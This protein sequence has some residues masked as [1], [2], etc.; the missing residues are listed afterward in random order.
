MEWLA[1]RRALVPL[2]AF[3]TL[4]A[5]FDVL[6]QRQSTELT[7]AGIQPA[8]VVTSFYEKQEFVMDRQVRAYDGEAGDNW[9]TRHKL[10]WAY[11]AV[12]VSVY[13][14][15]EERTSR[16]MVRYAIL[17]HYVAIF[18]LTFCF[19][20]LIL[21]EVAG[22]L[23][24]VTATL[25]MFAFVGLMSSILHISGWEENYSPI[26][27]MALAAAIYASL[28]RNLLLFFVTVFVAVSNRESGIALGL[29]YPILN[30]SSFRIWIAGPLFGAAALALLNLALLRQPEF[31]SLRN[32]VVDPETEFFTILNFYQFP[33]SKWGPPLLHYLAFVAP[34][35]LL[36][37]WT[38]SSSQG[39]R[40]LLL[41]LYYL[42]IFAVGSSIDNPFLFLVL[43]PIYALLFATA[44]RPSP[45]STLVS[46]G[47]AELTAKR[48]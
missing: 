32:F 39:R 28:R 40:A 6:W 29:V 46:G 47:N 12:E 5:I 18:F 45:P 26:E 2:V 34:V 9:D 19:C 21:R 35:L 48:E 20:L 27:M 30:P 14:F 15:V 4:I 31:Y 16:S 33:A 41:L 25:S 23:D 36:A 44:A 17:I 7:A 13:R 3:L 42:L 24:A 37:P 38:V 22:R 8:D 1:G 43:I 11:K 10:R